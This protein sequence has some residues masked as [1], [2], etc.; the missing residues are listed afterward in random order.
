M[1][2]QIKRGCPYKKQKRTHTET[3]GMESEI[4]VINP[5]NAKDCQ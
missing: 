5:A 2:A 3:Q 1:W 4:G